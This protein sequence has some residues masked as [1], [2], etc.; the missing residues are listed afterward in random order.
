MRGCW[1]ENAL[2]E[3]GELCRTC[4]PNPFVN[5]RYVHE[6]ARAIAARRAQEPDFSKWAQELDDAL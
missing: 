2:G 1:G 4:E 5:P 3:A 6:A